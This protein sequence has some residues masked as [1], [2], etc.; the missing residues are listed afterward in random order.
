MAEWQGQALSFAVL[1]PGSAKPSLLVVF[2]TVHCALLYVPNS[3]INDT[4]LLFGTGIA[5]LPVR[6]YRCKM[7][8]RLIA[9]SD[10]VQE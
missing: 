3:L 2:Y 4:Q 6:I 1:V 7:K 8:V 10:F 9:E 5:V